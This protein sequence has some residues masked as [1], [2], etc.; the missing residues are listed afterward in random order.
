MIADEVWKLYEF[1]S[2]F[3]RDH[4]AI[5]KEMRDRWNWIWDHDHQE[6]IDRAYALLRERGFE[7]GGL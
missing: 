2:D 3:G 7:D 1:A 5:G 6:D 4:A